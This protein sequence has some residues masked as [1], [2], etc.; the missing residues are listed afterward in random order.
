LLAGRS[1]RARRSS[2]L[3]R[4]FLGEILTNAALFPAS[5]EASW[6]TGAVLPV[7][8]GLLAGT[9]KIMQEIIKTE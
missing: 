9:S 2:G 7:D 1:D 3:A 8:G 4:E 5:D 6:I